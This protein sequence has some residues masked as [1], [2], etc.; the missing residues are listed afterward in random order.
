MADKIAVQAMDPSMK[1]SPIAGP[2]EE[3]STVMLDAASKICHWNGQEF[4]DGQVIDCAGQAYECS[5]GQWV[6]V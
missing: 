6:K 4:D 2:V 3:E 5:F 1:N